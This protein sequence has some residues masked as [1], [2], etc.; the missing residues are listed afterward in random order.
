MDVS[1]IP[2]ATIKKTVGEG[3]EADIQ[4][5]VLHVKVQHEF[6]GGEVIVTDPQTNKEYR[7][8]FVANTAYLYKYR[9]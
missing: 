5:G 8:V 9:R 6:S 7:Y 1:D 4:D 3:I 2:D